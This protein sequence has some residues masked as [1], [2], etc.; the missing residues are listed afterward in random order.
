MSRPFKQGLDYFPL[1]VELDDK[2]E[3]IEAKHGIEGFGI[4]IK[5][6]QRIYKEGYFLNLNEEF[7]LLFSKR[8][9]ADI[10]KVNAVI[11]DCLCYHLFDKTLHEKYKILTSAGIQK[12]YFTAIERRKDLSL[13]KNYI[14][15]D[16]NSINA[17]INWINDDNNSQSKV[18]ESKEDNINIP[19]SEFWELYDKKVGAKGKCQKKWNKLSDDIRQKII[20]TLPAFK[21]SIRDKQ[22]QPFP[23]TY[24]NQERWNDEVKIT[25]EVKFTF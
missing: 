21:K 11:K 25:E 6:L 24:L 18:K 16:I 23:E 2:V 9:N 22:F 10:N 17:N 7:V 15:A 4:F 19:F 1:D 5:L 13:I 8:I 3:L 20:D 14:I 12:R